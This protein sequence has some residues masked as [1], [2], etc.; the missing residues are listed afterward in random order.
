M[1]TDEAKKQAVADAMAVGLEYVES[2]QT[3]RLFHTW[4]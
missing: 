1:E 2:L 3:G 4:R